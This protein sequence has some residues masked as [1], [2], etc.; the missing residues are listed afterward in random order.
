MT[1]DNQPGSTARYLE[2][3]RSDVE[4]FLAGLSLDGEPGELYDACRYVISGGGKRVRPVATILAGEVH[5]GMR[6]DLLPIAAAFEVFHNFTLVHDDVMDRSVTRRGRDTVHV[7]WDESMAILAGDLLLGVAYELLSAAPPQSAGT[8]RTSF[9]RMVRR[10]CEGQALDMAFETAD[11]VAIDEYIKMIDGKTGAL[12][13]CCLECGALAAG[14]SVDSAENMHRA[15]L[16]LGRAF[17]VQDDLLDATAEGDRWG[18]RRGQD[19]LEGKR[20]YL[21]VDALAQGGEVSDYF[22]RALNRGGFDASEVDEAVQRLRGAGT[23][24][25]AESR[26]AE[27]SESASDRIQQLPAGAARDALVALIDQLNRRT[28]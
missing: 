19:L 5:G 2:G 1:A 23:I 6:N 26:V 24:A 22:R 10:L 13:A 21:V 9:G 7:K 12:L 4:A 14:A 3:I 18:K 17:Q 8:I 28:H 16:E 15:G 27:H 25:R 20:T 11:D